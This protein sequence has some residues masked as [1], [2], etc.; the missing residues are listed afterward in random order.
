MRVKHWV[1]S[2]AA[3]LAVLTTTPAIATTSCGNRADLGPGPRLTIL[4]LTQDQRLVQF[5]ECNPNRLKEIGAVIVAI[6]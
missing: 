4:G 5:R 1:L 6:A 2:V 3:I